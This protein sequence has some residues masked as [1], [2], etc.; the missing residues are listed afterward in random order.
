[1]RKAEAVTLTI[2]AIFVIGALSIVEQKIQHFIT[3]GE[4]TTQQVWTLV[5]L[6]E[7]CIPMI[8]RR[9]C[10]N[11]NESVDVQGCGRWFSDRNATR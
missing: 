10:N 6:N 5:P 4:C 3:D 1:M 11:T 2:L 9:D 8:E 7:N